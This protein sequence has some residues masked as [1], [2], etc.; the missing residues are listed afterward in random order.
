MRCI[1]TESSRRV[2]VFCIPEKVAVHAGKSRGC[3][4]INIIRDLHIA[5][6]FLLALL[7]NCAGGV[8]VFSPSLPARS[9]ALSRRLLRCVQRER[10]KKQESKSSP[11][12]TGG[13]DLEFLVNQPA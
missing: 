9:S 1:A 11:V 7:P 12:W 13:S 8:A 3:A 4:A 6:L 5:F 2:S 10:E